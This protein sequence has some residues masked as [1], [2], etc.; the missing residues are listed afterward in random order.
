MGFYVKK[1]KQQKY[2]IL[3]M[4]DCALSQNIKRAVLEGVSGLKKSSQRPLKL[5]TNKKNQKW[6]TT[7]LK[8]I[9]TSTPSSL[10]GT[11]SFTWI[12]KKL[13]SPAWRK[14]SS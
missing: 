9:A 4:Y 13:I 1:K 14:I 3:T 7:T 5:Q 11:A 6:S 2:Q 12:T 8:N 10:R